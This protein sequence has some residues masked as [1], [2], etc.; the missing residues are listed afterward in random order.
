MRPVYSLWLTALLL[1]A[2]VVHAESSGKQAL[3]VSKK[4]LVTL[5]V[6]LAEGQVITVPR[7]LLVTRYGIP[8]VF[9]VENNEARFRMVRPG[10]TTTK[11]VEILSGL[12]GHE[13]LLADK[14]DKVHDGSLLEISR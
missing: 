4:Q 2:G 8:G 3:S 11:Q 9:V 10:K 12:F 6:N 5:S 14:L 1:I 13:M 7:A